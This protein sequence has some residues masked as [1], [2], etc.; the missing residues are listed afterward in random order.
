MFV[1]ELSAAPAGIPPQLAAE[2]RPA[3]RYGFMDAAGGRVRVASWNAPAGRGTAR[4]TA[5]VLGGRGEFIEKYASEVAG[6][7]LDRGFAVQ[8]MDW[9][10]QGLSDR[11]LP[12]RSKGH[13]DDFA[14]YV[15]DLKLFFE[16]IVAPAASGPTI[17]ICH[18][19]GAH[20]LLR[21]LGEQGS[22][23][24][25]AALLTAPMSGL[26]REALLK[27][28]LF[29]MPNRP[30]VEQRYLYGSG[31][32][33]LTNRSF[34]INRLTHDERRFHFT[35]QWFAADPRL[36]LG[37]PTVGWA[38]QAVRSMF[39]TAQPGFLERIAVPVT[40]VSAGEDRLVEPRTH[41]AMVKR[42]EAGEL[43]V[44]Q[45]ARHE[46]MMEIEPIRARFWDAFDR[47]AKRIGA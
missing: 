7:L 35:D 25:A 47:L 45:D 42:L 40:V 10:G 46:V 36:S 14:T 44:L 15:A 12:D 6:E 24:L 23:P 38:R 30:A 32:F 31:P 43:V 18:S 22:G 39:L 8:A 3:D 17:C 28:A 16:G 41:V 33:T 13:I 26:K 27:A 11:L 4:R 29:L 5:V 19:M 34:A 21:Y 20:I 37:G 2:H 1:T 9:R